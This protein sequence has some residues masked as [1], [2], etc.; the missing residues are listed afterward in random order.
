MFIPSCH[1]RVP[2]PALSWI[3]NAGTSL[4]L[5][6]T[7]IFQGHHV[8]TEKLLLDGFKVENSSRESCPRDNKTKVTTVSIRWDQIERD[9]N[10]FRTSLYEREMKS[11]KGRMDGKYFSSP[12]SGIDV[13]VFH[14]LLPLNDFIFSLLHL[15]P[16]F[17]FSL[18]YVMQFFL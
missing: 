4:L 2:L 14:F 8:F 12:K 13:F 17:S 3:H 5:G 7:T 11:H 6:D 16:Y 1:F 9:F 10:K 18:I 15:F